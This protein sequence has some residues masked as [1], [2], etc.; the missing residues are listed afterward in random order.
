MPQIWLMTDERLGP[1][2]LSSVQA[3]PRGGGIVFRHYSLPDARRH[4]LFM[5]V[6]RIARRRGLLLLLAGPADQARRWGADGYHLRHLRHC[7]R[8]RLGTML[9]SAPVH[10]PSEIAANRASSDLYFLSPV[11]PTRSHPGGRTLGPMRF[12]RLAALCRGPVIA[13]GGMTG[14]R[15]QMLRGRNARSIAYGWAA[16][17]ALKKA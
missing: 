16:I 4:A 14:P 9:H 3:L 11:Y 15:F 2:L 12:G 13:L 5:Q 10:T 6:R 17:S 8:I 1:A 7:R